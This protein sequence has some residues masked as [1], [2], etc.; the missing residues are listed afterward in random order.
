MS[1]DSNTPQ[2]IKRQQIHVA[3]SGEPLSSKK[4]TQI[5]LQVYIGF[6]T[7]RRIGICF[8]KTDNTLPC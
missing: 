7:G 6:G 4:Q 3:D 8:A 5:T 2:I 1:D